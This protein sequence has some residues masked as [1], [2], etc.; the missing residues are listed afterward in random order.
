MVFGWVRSC[1]GLLIGICYWLGLRFDCWI[2]T[3]GVVV[4]FSGCLLG[5]L[6]LRVLIS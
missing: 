6:G 5:G 2:L 4:W 1:C 3:I